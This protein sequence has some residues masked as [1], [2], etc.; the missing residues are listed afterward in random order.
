MAVAATFS[1]KI[2]GGGLIFLQ[3]WRRWPHFPT[4]LA[5]AA[6]FSYKIGDGGKDL[7][8]LLEAVLTWSGYWIGVFRFLPIF[9]FLRIGGFRGRGEAQ[10]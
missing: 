8:T 2:G 6:S 3:N 5:A 9:F 10:Y 4:K 1:Y 7:A